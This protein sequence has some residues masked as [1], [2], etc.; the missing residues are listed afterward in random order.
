MTTV[1]GVY[2]GEMGLEQGAASN[3]GDSLIG[4]ANRV[5]S[6]GQARVLV[7]VRDSV[8]SCCLM[9]KGSEWWTDENHGPYGENNGGRGGGNALRQ[10]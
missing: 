5:R 1:D 8:S 3:W 2:W 4:W 6:D 10:S 9:M 7:R